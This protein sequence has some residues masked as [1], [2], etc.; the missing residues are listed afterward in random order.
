MAVLHEIIAAG[1]GRLA[2]ALS[3]QVASEFA[4]IVATETIR[5]LGFEK[6][7]NGGMESVRKLMHD[8]GMKL[9]MKKVG[10]YVDCTV[11]C[12]FAKQIHPL[13]SDKSICPIALLILGAERSKRDG[14]LFDKL[15]LTD[16]GV[17]VTIGPNRFRR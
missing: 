17:R 4:G 3:P 15:S 2:A 11:D 14:V 5:H 16:D 7:A 6:D 9:S 8:L 13:L 12:P 1:N 10:E